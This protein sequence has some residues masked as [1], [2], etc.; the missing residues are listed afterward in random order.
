MFVSGPKVCRWRAACGAGC[1]AMGMA[2]MGGCFLSRCKVTHYSAYN[3]NKY[4]GKKYHFYGN[5][6]KKKKGSITPPFSHLL[7]MKHLLA[8]SKADSNHHKQNQNLLCYHYT[9][10]HCGCKGN[11]FWA[12]GQIF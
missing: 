11:A 10:G 1:I 6:Q 7:A 3:R 8:L 9:I 2:L 12:N 4:S 5:A